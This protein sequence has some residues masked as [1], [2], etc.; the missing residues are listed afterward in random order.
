[1]MDSFELLSCLAA[2][3]LTPREAATLLSVDPKT[4]MRWLDADGEISGPAEQAIRAW[5]P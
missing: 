5:V 2:L 4:V 3:R 1:M